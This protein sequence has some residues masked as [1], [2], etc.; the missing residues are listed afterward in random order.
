VADKKPAR[1]ATFLAEEYRAAETAEQ[2]GRIQQAWHHLERAHVVAQ[3][4]LGTHCQS[5]WKMLGLAVRQRA[6]VEIGAQIARLALAPLGNL[7]G[8]LPI[9]N[10]GRSNVSAFA[11]MEIPPDLQALLN[12]ASD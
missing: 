9:G 6:W 2:A 12:P 11:R 1:I 7:T 5:H 4:R 8:Y 3:T 10:T